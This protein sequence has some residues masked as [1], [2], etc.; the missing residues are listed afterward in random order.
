ML[1]YLFWHHPNED[2]ARAEYES[3]L[4]AFHLT[5][6]GADAKGLCSSASFRV[7]GLPWI[8]ESGAAY[9]DWY[10]VDDW[11]AFGPLNTLSVN[12]ARK[13]P[14]DRAA[15]AMAFGAGGIYTLRAGEDGALDGPSAQWIAK[16]KGMAY[17]VFDDLVQPLLRDGSAL[18]RRTMVLGPGLEFCVTGRT[19][20]A[21]P[22]PLS[23]LSVR[24]A[25]IAL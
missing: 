25:P 11:S 22:K 23:A 8:N 9:E 5:L 12:G 19:P 13:E 16:P 15:G 18:W 3:R 21:L 4:D 1:A 7:S 14:H 2:C 20:R 24:R 17:E 10:V 6:R